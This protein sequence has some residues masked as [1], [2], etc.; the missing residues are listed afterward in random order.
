M[1]NWRNLQFF[2]FWV[3]DKI[4]DFY[5]SLIDKL[6]IFFKNWIDIIHDFSC[7]IDILTKFKFFSFMIHEIPDIFSMNNWQKDMIIFH[8]W[9]TKSAV[10]TLMTDWRNAQ[11]SMCEI[12]VFFWE[13]W[14]KLSFFPVKIIIF[15]I[16]RSHVFEK[17]LSNVEAPFIEIEMTIFLFSELNFYKF[18]NPNEKQKELILKCKNGR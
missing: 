1:N 3:T 18:K 12:H 9:L 17:Y 7:K 11:L 4:W 10:L 6:A 16:N 13:V 15:M 14:T 8:N 5:Q 2:S